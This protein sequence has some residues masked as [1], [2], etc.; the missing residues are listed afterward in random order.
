VFNILLK[1]VSE[2]FNIDEKRIFT[3]GF[4]GG[5][6]LAIL[7]TQQ[8]PQIIGVAACGGSIPIS[9]DRQPDFYY[10]GI[11]G[12]EDFNYLEVSQLFTVFNNAGFDYT[13]VVFDGGHQWPPVSSFESAI[14]GFEIFSIKSNRKEKNTEWIDNVWEKM[15]DSINILKKEK[16]IIQENICISQTS[17][18]FYGLKNIKELKK[19]SYKIMRSQEFYNRIKH[20]QSLIQKEVKLRAEFIKAIE[21]KDLDWWRKEIEQINKTSQNGDKEI[22]HI[23]KRLLNYLSMVSYMLTKSDLDDDKLEKVTKKLKIYELVDPENP[24]VY[25]MYSRYYM[26]LGD[27]REMINNFKK[28]QSLNFTDYNIY[29]KEFSWE[30]LFANDNIKKLYESFTEK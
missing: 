28:A 12:N 1:E 2:R 17:R 14:I 18:W 21:N 27:N 29:K 22:A 8:Y 7:F 25:L 4:S 23:S 10:A 11:V 15:N 16:N 20:R 3:A 6:K 26:L 24:D 13:S 19:R 9:S 30:K 5:A